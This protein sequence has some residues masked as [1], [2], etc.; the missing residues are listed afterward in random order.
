MQLTLEEKQEISAILE[1]GCGNGWLSNHLARHF[2]VAQVLGVDIC[3]K[4]LLQ[5]QEIF[6]D[7]HNL[8]FC[9]ADV[10]TCSLP[11]KFF[12]IILLAGVMPYI[13]NLNLLFV[14]L[15][16][17]LSGL[18]EIH[19]V[20]SPI[21]NNNEVER[22]RARSTKYFDKNK[23][24]DMKQYFYSHGWKSIDPFHYQVLYNPTTVVQRAKRFLNGDSPFPW[25]SIQKTL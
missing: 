2:P 1:I 13:Q 4:E 3:E 11:N 5:G 22:A 18:G 21:Y 9:Y 16:E 8:H 14:R 20:D 7:Q 15:F 6:N 25:I 10:H 19:I 23:M 12:D 24:P 17:S